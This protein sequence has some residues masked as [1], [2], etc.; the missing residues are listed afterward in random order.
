MTIIYVIIAI[1]SFW[2]LYYFFIKY[3]VRRQDN[4]TMKAFNDL[5]II[6]EDC[7]EIVNKK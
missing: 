6:L 7:I 2:I 4:E 5:R 1:F 3:L